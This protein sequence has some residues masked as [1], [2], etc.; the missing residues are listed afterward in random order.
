MW[1]CVGAVF[2]IASVLIEIFLFEL[3]EPL[4]SGSGRVKKA[5]LF[6]A[7]VALIVPPFRVSDAVFL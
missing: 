1:F 7:A 3:R 5:A 6:G 2:V 4:V